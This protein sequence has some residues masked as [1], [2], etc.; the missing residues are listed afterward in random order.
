MERFTLPAVLGLGISLLHTGSVRRL[1]AKS[2][3]ASL[4]KVNP[5]GSILANPMRKE[6][7]IKL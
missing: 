7:F 1:V 2:C 4:F 5:L 6:T 3:G